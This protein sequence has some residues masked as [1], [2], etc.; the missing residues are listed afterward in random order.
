MADTLYKKKKNRGGEES[1]PA[2]S[3]WSLEPAAGDDMHN[4]V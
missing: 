2:D 1:I 3:S 4:R